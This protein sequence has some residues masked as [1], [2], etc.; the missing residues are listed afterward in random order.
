MKQVGE[1]EKIVAL[2]NF[3][4]GKCNC[5]KIIHFV[6]QLDTSNVT[7]YDSNVFATKHFTII[8]TYFITEL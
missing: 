8:F 7:V 2:Q 6:N 4:A 3:V 5:E 1:M